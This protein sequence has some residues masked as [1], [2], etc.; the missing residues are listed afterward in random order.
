M[1]VLLILIR[2]PLA[3]VMV[4]RSST[5]WFNRAIRFKRRYTTM[6]FSAPR[7]GMSRRLS[8]KLSVL[9]GSFFS[10]AITAALPTQHLAAELV[11][12][13]NYDSAPVTAIALT[14]DSSVL[15]APEAWLTIVGLTGKNGGEM[16]ALCDVCLRA[17]SDSTPLIQQNHITA[18][19]IVC[20]LVE[21]RFFSRAKA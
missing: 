12:R 15:I 4:T 16:A 10:L 3:G 17:P 1:K 2:S 21:E 9:A 14:T 20:G 13:L 7:F 6:Y 11:G 18:G 19:H 5:I 8:R